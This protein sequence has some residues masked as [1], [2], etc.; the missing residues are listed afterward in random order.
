MWYFATGCHY[1]IPTCFHFFDVYR[2]QPINFFF[3]LY[4]AWDMFFPQILLSSVSL[5]QQ[6]LQCNWW[7]FTIIDWH[8][9][10]E[11]NPKRNFNNIH[12]YSG[13][14]LFIKWTQADKAVAEEKLEKARPALEEAE[15][16]LQTI[17]ASDISTVRKLGKPPHLIMR[18][19]DCVLLLFQRKLDPMAMDPER[20]GPKPSWGES[21]KVT[22]V[23]LGEMV[24]KDNYM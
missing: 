12:M 17:K 5:W 9:M 22:R 13:V 21:L 19:M 15:L 16:A 14:C 3:L 1:Y 24:P 11:H 4:N 18:I 20:P 10:P 2:A 7:M 8:C 6:K 23:Y